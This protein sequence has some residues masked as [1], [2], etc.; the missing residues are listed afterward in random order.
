MEKRYFTEFLQ[1]GTLRLC[2]KI[3]YS[4]DRFRDG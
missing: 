4:C 1:A 2:Y 3:C